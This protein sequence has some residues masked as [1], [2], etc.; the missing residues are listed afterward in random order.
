[1]P[2]TKRTIRVAGLDVDQD[3]FVA[4]LR[5]KDPATTRRIVA[6][7]K[8]DRTTGASLGLRLVAQAFGRELGGFIVGL[9]NADSA[10]VESILSETLERVYTRIDR[11]DSGKSAFRTWAYE[12]ARYAVL[13]WYRRCSRA[14]TPIDPA[15]MGDEQSLQ[16]D[17]P[18]FDLPGEVEAR[19]PRERAAVRSAFRTLKPAERELLWWRYVEGKTP[20]EISRS[21]L[22]RGIPEDHVKVYVN[23]AAKKLADAFQREME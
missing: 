4:K 2:G 19:S 7:L 14:P 21:G 3:R 6:Q 9:S 11:F 12:Q 18:G 8:R 1:V 16:A 5:A 23:R 13:D 10:E 22:A 15:R 17:S 20:T